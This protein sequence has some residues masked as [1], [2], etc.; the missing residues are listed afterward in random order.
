VVN[1]VGLAI[2]LCHRGFNVFVGAV[3]NRD[4]LVSG[5][6]VADTLHTEDT[7]FGGIG[8]GEGDEKVEAEGVV[9]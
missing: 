5:G 6:R 7:S 9:V 2:T 8:V 3:T 1:H 4:G